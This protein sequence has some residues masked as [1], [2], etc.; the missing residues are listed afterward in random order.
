MENR[1]SSTKLSEATGKKLDI[2]V[3]ILHDLI[4]SSVANHKDKVAMICKHQAAD[5]L[6]DVSSYPTGPNLIERP[7]HLVW[8]HGQLQH[9]ADLLA[10][11]LAKRGLQ[12]GSSIAV[13]LSGR[14]EFH[15]VLRA[16]VKLKCPFTPMNLRSAQNAKEIRHMLTLSDSKAVIVEDAELAE[17]LEKNVPDLMSEMQLKVVVDRASSAGSYLSLSDL[18]SDAAHDES[19]EAQNEV[20]EDVPRHL[21][22]VVFIWFTSGTTSLP[23][24]APHTNKSLTCNVRS[25]AEAF[26]LDDK[27]A[28]LHICKFVLKRLPYLSSRYLTLLHSTDELK[29]VVLRR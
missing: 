19:F 29:C 22:D 24:A 4:S 14:A 18:V 20:L 21:E 27:R 23:K 25:W 12:P 5:L 17:H 2:P 7:P 13:L 28:W 9:G 10:H 1:S 6:P 16:A 11:A 15:L 26:N 8:T 3:P